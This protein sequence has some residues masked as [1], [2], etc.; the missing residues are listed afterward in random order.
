MWTPSSQHLRLATVLLPAI[1]PLSSHGF[2]ASRSKSENAQCLF[3]STAHEQ[4]E[5][6]LMRDEIAQ[7]KKEASMRLDKLQASI[8]TSNKLTA[9]TGV[10][11]IANTK[12]DIQTAISSV[13]SHKILDPNTESRLD[14]LEDT[15][16]KV[17]LNVGREQGTWMPQDW[18]MSG[19][20][21]L[22]HCDIEFTGEQL[23]D[24]EEFLGG[25]GGARKLNVVDNTAT[26]GPTV[27]ANSAPVAIKAT[28]GWKIVPKEGPS[29][30][31]LLR[32]YVE[33]EDE[34][35]RGDV[36]CPAG[37]V[38]ATCGY[39]VM[40]E[41]K[42]GSSV[43]DAIKQEYE[44]CHMR[45]EKSKRDFEEAPVWSK[46]GKRREMWQISSEAKQLKLK[47]LSA[48]VRYPE[49]EL[50]RL[51]G[52]VGLTREGGICC[53]VA[54]GLGIEYHILGKF[55]VAASE[56]RNDKDNKNTLMP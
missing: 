11:D 34:V 40:D 50:L 1:L 37:R 45:L 44:E 52:G 51:N 38:Y 21:L 12:S 42:S 30:S 43:K 20:R 26:L 9:A 41:T 14:T 32:F 23:Y 4:D 24:K 8:S 53:K 7:L 55:G 48:Q 5:L 31:D 29:G 6:Q 10:D 13:P 28:G 15:R 56:K 35:K 27:S 16:W 25:L 17:V 54:K 22:I 46:L 33:L 18:G 49:R 2:V 36:S 47:Y 39:F 19:D 3:S